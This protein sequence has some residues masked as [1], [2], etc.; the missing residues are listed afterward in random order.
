MNPYQA[1]HHPYPLSAH[2]DSPRR[3]W[4]QIGLALLLASGWLVLNNATAQLRSTVELHSGTE[5]SI[6]IEQLQGGAVAAPTQVVPVPVPLT[7][8]QPTPSHGAAIGM[9]PQESTLLMP[10]QFGFDSA[11]LAP[12]AR[13]ILN[14]VAEAMLDP[15]LRVSRFIIEG[16][17]DATGSWQ[18]NAGLSERRAQAVAQYLVQRGVESQRLYIVGYSWNRLLPGLAP[19]DQRHRRVEIGRM[20]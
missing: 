10:V 20:H 11:V 17:T 4:L 3:R 9:T 19:T 16:H 5:R 18:Y 2:E 8:V 1:T 12:E 14:V 13:T 15:S 6:V 7:A